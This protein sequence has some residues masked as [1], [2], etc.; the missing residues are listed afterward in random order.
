[1]EQLLAFVLGIGA[2]VV[3]SFLY[4]W[5]IWRWSFKVTF[6]NVLSDISLLKR[7]IDENQ[8]EPDLILAVDRT[9]P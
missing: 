6:D 9:P 8:F 3:A 4:A 2:S 7:R 1:M 5:L